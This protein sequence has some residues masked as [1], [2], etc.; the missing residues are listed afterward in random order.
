MQCSQISHRMTTCVLNVPLVK[1]VIGRSRRQ[2][3][4]VRGIIKTIGGPLSQTRAVLNPCLQRLKAWVLLAQEVMRSEFPEFEAVASMAV[5]DLHQPMDGTSAEIPLRRLASTFGMDSA[6]LISEW[7][8][9]QPRAKYLHA[10]ARTMSNADAWRS[11][12][13]ETQ[14]RQETRARHPKDFWGNRRQTR[15]F[16]FDVHARHMKNGERKNTHVASDNT[17]SQTQSTTRTRSV[18]CSRH[19]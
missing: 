7:K 17:E 12:I 19:M 11:A 16:Y 2:V 9:F 15:R 8:D 6:K 3:F 14:T 10:E 5:F 18:S 1:S 4:A 13:A